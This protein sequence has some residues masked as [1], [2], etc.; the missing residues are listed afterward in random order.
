MPLEIDVPPIIDTHLAPE[1]KPVET[2]ANGKIKVYGGHSPK[3][4]IDIPKLNAHVVIHKF[5]PFE[6]NKIEEV[7][8]ILVRKGHHRN[9]LVVAFNDTKDGGPYD[10]DVLSP[11]G[12]IGKASGKRLD[13]LIGSLFHDDPNLDEFI[14]DASMDDSVQT[15][16]KSILTTTENPIHNS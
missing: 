2:Y 13:L 4:T 6:F 9:H 11:N 3:T 1:G 16:L 14:N 12:I 10:Y 5:G 15:Y 7:N 8:E